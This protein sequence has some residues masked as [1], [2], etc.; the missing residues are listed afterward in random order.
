MDAPDRNVAEE[1]RALRRPVDL[2]ED[3]AKQRPELLAFWPHYARP[4][5]ILERSGRKYV[6]ANDGS[7]RCVKE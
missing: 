6:V 5:T 3:P 2:R 1:E 4:G 7:V